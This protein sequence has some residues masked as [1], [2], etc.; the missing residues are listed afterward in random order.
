MSRTSTKSKK[1]PTRVLFFVRVVGSLFIN[2]SFSH[3]VA[4]QFIISFIVCTFRGHRPRYAS[5]PRTVNGIFIKVCKDFAFTGK[6]LR[7]TTDCIIRLFVSEL[8]TH[9]QYNPFRIDKS[10]L[11]CLQ[12]QNKFA[13]SKFLLYICRL[14]VEIGSAQK[15]Q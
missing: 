4:V 9:G 10:I 3:A 1:A 15:K 13:Y 7:R 5:P 6:R 14:F 12:K 11:F 8:P 2:S